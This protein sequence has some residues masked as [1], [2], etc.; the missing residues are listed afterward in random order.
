MAMTD[1]ELQAV[2]GEN[3]IRARYRAKLAQR[4]V[5]AELQT[6]QAQLSRWERGITSPHA[7]TLARLAHIY[8]IPMDTLFVKD[9]PMLPPPPPPPVKVADED[10]LGPPHPINQPTRAGRPGLPTKRPSRS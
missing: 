2:L 5:A 10:D 7:V 6:D 3:L 4:E 9:H 8:D 1:V